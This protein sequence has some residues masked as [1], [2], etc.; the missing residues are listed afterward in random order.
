MI[1]IVL[2]AGYATRMYPL[3][4]NAPKPLLKVQE[5]PILNWLL[6]NIDE[7]PGIEQ[8]LIISNP[9]FIS[10]FEAWS[11]EQHYTKS[12]TVLDDGSSTNETRIG[13]VR[14]IQVALTH[15]E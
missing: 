13:A 2:A 3:T 10:H 15:M 1:C 12:L 8:I 7:I 11:K 6:G 14:D 5:K 4:E 9:K